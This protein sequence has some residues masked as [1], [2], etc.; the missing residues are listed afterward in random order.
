MPSPESA[1]LRSYVEQLIEAVRAGTMSL[2]E[3]NLTTFVWE[4]NA[5]QP[6]RLSLQRLERLERIVVAGRPSQQKRTIFL[7]QVSDLKTNQIRVSFNGAEDPELNK[8]LEAL[9]QV[10]R[11][12]KTRNDLEFLKSILPKKTD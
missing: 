10:I 2:T 7:L 12:K 3:V 9:Y 11:E 1:E 8:L 4:T 6:T 5:P